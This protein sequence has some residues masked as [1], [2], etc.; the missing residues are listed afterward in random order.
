MAD[1][2][3][4]YRWQCTGEVVSFGGGMHCN[5]CLSNLLINL[6]AYLYLLLF[7]GCCVC[8]PTKDS[9]YRRSIQTHA[10]IFA[11]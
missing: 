2:G 10:D 1:Q 5:E 6:L 8:C 9:I 4:V 11:S 7:C 3:S